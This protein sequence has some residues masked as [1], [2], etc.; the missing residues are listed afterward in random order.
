MTDRAAGL[1]PGQTR[2]LSRGSAPGHYWFFPDLES[3]LFP[4]DEGE[5]DWC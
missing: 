5:A 4:E 3:E 2:A 1:L